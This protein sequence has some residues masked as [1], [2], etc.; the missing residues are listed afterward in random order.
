M[1]PFFKH[2]SMRVTELGV[3]CSGGDR[4]WEEHEP[5]RG[6]TAAQSRR[7]SIRPLIGLPTAIF[8]KKWLVSTIS[9]GLSCAGFCR[10]GRCQRT[11]N[12][13]RENHMPAEAKMSDRNGKVL[14]RYVKLMVTHNRQSIIDVI[15]YV[16]SSKLPHKFLKS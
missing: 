11:E 6:C 4:D 5:V 10:K 3:L 15:K 8:R 1:G 7:R 14:P 9:G 13:I 2:M 16:G 12:Q